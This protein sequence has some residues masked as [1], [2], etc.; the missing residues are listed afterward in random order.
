MRLK[1]S[2]FVGHQGIGHRMRLVKAIA[3]KVLQKR[4][5]LIAKLFGDI[6]QTFGAVNKRLTH[7]IQLLG[8][9]F[10]HSA[11]QNI[12]LS[13]CKSCQG[14]G[15]LHNLLLV[16][17]YAVGILQDRLH[18]GVQH[19]GRASAMA[20]GNEVLGHACPQGAG[21][22]Q[23]HQRDQILKAFRRKL[24]QQLGNPGRFQLKDAGC[25][26]AA[27]HSAGC[28]VIKGDVINIHS[29]ARRFADKADAVTDNRQRT[30]SQ[31]VHLQKAQLFHLVFVVLGDYAALTALLQRHVIL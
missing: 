13:Q 19:L 9:L 22:V 31:K 14:R 15:Y 21:A 28:L 3:G 6:V 29:L 16:Q 2:S 11:A 10:A 17:N 27:Q 18:Q 20:A 8:L 12:S 25:L 7:R 26:A 23:R 30:Q 5:D 24:H 4:K 1:I